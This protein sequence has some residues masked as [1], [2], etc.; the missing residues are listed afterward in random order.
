MSGEGLGSTALLIVCM[1]LVIFAAYYTTKFLSSKSRN[2]TKCRYMQVK[3]RMFF[4]KDKLIVLLEAGDKV[5]LIGITNQTMAVIGTLQKEE[6]EPL[7]EAVATPS[8]FSG[9]KS[10]MGKV[11]EFIKNTR[12]AQ[13]ELRKANMQTKKRNKP[14]VEPE[15][16]QGDDIERILEAMNQR[17]TRFSKR[18]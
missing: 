11:T 6:L 16:Q 2:L 10:F 8:V 3:D 14:Y 18:D 7:A 9:M 13:E 17:K 15:E 1:L 12:H 4:G 5:F